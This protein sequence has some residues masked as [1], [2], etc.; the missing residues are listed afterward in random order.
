MPTETRAAHLALLAAFVC[1]ALVAVQSRM[2]GRLAEAVGSF[3]AAWFSFGSGLVVLSLL[4][5]R[6]EQRARLARV[7]AALRSGRLARWQVLGGVGGGLLVGTQTYAVPIVGVAAFLIAT[8]GGQTVSALVVDRFGLGSAPAQALVRA[9][10]VAACAAVGGVAIAATAGVGE[11][12]PEV[13]PVVLGFLV[14]MGVAVQ[15]AVNGRVTTIT[16]APTA[17]AWVNFL[18]G[19]STLLVLGTVPVWLGGWPTAWGSVPPWAWWGGLCGVCFIALAAWA[20]Q[21]SGVLLFGLVTITSQLAVALVLDLLNPATRDRVGL[22]MLL[23]V[24]VTVVAAM[25]AAR[26]AG[27]ARRAA[28]PG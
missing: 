21:H 10:V 23:G 15:Q 13:L 27:A 16:G 17:T 8:I 5:V 25:S 24:T 7:P 28:V 14:G 2:N 18:M 9:R 6:R 22:Q 19:S 26:A 12:R 1:G 4:L 11:V 3:P 20:V